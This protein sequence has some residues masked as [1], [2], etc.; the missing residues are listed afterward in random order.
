MSALAPRPARVAL[1]GAV[2]LACTPAWSHAQAGDAGRPVPAPQDPATRPDPHAHS[3]HDVAADPHAGHRHGAAHDSSGNRRDEPVPGVSAATDPATRAGL[4]AGHRQP[5]QDDARATHAHHPAVQGPS[6]RT[7][8][9]AVPAMTPHAPVPPPT[10]ADRA[11]AFPPLHHAHAPHG[12]GIHSLVR[13]DRFEAWDATSG[14]GQAWEG[15]AWIGGDVRRLWLRSEG[16]REHGRT[17]SAHLEALYGHAIGPWWDLVA[18]ARH[19]FAPGPSRTRAAIGVQGLAPYK[20]EMSAMAYLGDGG[21]AGFSVEAG[22]ELL[23][24]HRLI[25]QPT[26]EAELNAGSDPR[27]G[28]GSGLSSVEAGLRLR[29]EIT[30]RFA[31]YIGLAHERGFGGTADHRRDEGGPAGRTRWVAGVRGWF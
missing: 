22:Y 5:A 12:E 14:R 21:R 27:R 24:T 25:L 29:Y 18:G 23:L 7:A 8:A 10:E 9:V 16:E 31:P 6:A 15:S 4:H 26:L 20:F 28:I 2:L 19:D 17:D 30:R 1:A 3:L 11:A 13:F